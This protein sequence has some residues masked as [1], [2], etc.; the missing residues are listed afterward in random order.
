[1]ESNSSLTKTAQSQNNFILLPNI[2]EKLGSMCF[3]IV[4]KDKKEK[5]I[6]NCDILVQL[7]TIV[8]DYA[9][10]GFSRIFSQKI[11]FS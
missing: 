7:V 5:N 2:S 1:M 6:C 4:F 11:K 10:T 8:N 3:F 9:D